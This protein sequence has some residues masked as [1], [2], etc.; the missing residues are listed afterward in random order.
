MDNNF[1]KMPANLWD[2]PRVKYLCEKT[3]C[4]VAEIIGSLYW[5]WAY[6]HKHS[7]Q[8]VILGMRLNLFDRMAYALGFGAALVEIGW[9]WELHD[10]VLVIPV[11]ELN[12]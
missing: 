12:E 2:D 3:D 8:G 10:G 6:A 4:D 7:I 5:L 9:L 11:D 1:I